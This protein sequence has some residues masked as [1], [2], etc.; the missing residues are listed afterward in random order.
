MPADLNNKS[1]AVLFKEISSRSKS[2]A[3][4]MK[5]SLKSIIWMLNQL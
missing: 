3:A 2:K 5:Y 4:S 1:H